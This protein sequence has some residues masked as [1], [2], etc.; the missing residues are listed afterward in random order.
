MEAGVGSESEVQKMSWGEYPPMTRDAH[1]GDHGHC[2]HCGYMSVETL[3]HRQQAKLVVGYHLGGAPFP[4]SHGVKGALVLRCPRGVCGLL[5][6][7]HY[8]VEG[9]MS[10]APHVPGWPRG[11]QRRGKSL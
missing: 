1:A 8:S 10:L 3:T 5:F 9:A 7:C 6:W 11:E 4:N 2:P